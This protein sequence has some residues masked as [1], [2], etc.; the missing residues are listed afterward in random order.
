MPPLL[1][2]IHCCANIGSANAC[3]VPVSPYPSVLYTLAIATELKFFKSIQDANGTVT[4]LVSS[5]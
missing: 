3:P 1:N 4:S 5:Q 2:N